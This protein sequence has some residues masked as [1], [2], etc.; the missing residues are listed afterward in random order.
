MCQ[1]RCV[2]YR[3]GFRVASESVTLEA[4]TTYWYNVALIPHNSQ[5]TEGI[6]SRCRCSRCCY[7]LRYPAHAQHVAFPSKAT[8][9]EQQEAGN[10][11]DVA[12]F[13]QRGLSESATRGAINNRCGAWGT[14][15]HLENLTSSLLVIHLSL[16][17]TRRGRPKGI[18]SLKIHTRVYKTPLILRWSQPCLALLEAC[19]YYVQVLQRTGS[20][21]VAMIKA[22][23]FEMRIE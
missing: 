18:N 4:L 1:S 16:A 11:R 9:Q 14:Y 15:H 19:V 7:S 13:H 5:R 17:Q 12:C 22:R 10:V 20:C 8:P 2:S 21:C 23:T 3:T 6:S